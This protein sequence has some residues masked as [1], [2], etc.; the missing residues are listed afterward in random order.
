MPYF[1]AGASRTGCARIAK[2]C[3]WDAWTIGAISGSGGNFDNLFYKQFIDRFP[4]CTILTVKMLLNI[5]IKMPTTTIN[6]TYCPCVARGW[7]RLLVVGVGCGGGVCNNLLQILLAVP[8]VCLGNINPTLKS[9]YS[10][11]IKGQVLF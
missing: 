10:V 3:Q 1:R 7:A 2:L 9:R 11:Q 4:S 5:I 8:Q 6:Q